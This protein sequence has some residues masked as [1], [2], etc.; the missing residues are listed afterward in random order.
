MPCVGVS[1]ALRCARGRVGGL[2]EG[3]PEV[4][5]LCVFFM[6]LVH[7]GGQESHGQAVQW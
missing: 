3:V 1:A 7:D 6:Q 5:W 4:A 2:S